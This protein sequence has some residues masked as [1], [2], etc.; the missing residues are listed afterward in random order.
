MDMRARPIRAQLEQAASERRL[1]GLAMVN[2][3][4]IVVQ[5]DRGFLRERPRLPRRLVELI[6]RCTGCARRLMDMN[7][8]LLRRWCLAPAG[9]AGVL[10]LLL[11]VESVLGVLAGVRVTLLGDT[12]AV[13]LSV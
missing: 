3:C 8:P 2:D 10:Q 12:V 4:R 11:A 7:E 1:G 5:G 9:G 6:R 13:L